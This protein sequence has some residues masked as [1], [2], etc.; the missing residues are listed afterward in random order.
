MNVINRAKN[1]IAQP[2]LEWTVIDSEPANPGQIISGYVLPLA[3]LA[4]IAAFIGYGFIGVGGMF[5][6]RVVG[7]N[8]GLYQ[9]LSV[10]VGAIISVYITALV[11][12]VLAPSFNS[13]KNFGRSLQLV[14]YSFTP[15]WIGGLLNIFPPIAMIGALFGLYGFYLMYVG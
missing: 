2:R 8:W 13:Q 9:A 4:A 3:G 14:A 6:F 7:I 12:D 1:I 10:L 15:A 11:V 5:G